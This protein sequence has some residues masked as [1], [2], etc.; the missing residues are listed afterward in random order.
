MITD[1]IVKLIDSVLNDEDRQ[2]LMLKHNKSTPPGIFIEQFKLLR[3]QVPRGL[4]TTTAA[5]KLLE[6]YDG[7]IL[8]V[9]NNA[10]LKYNRTIGNEKLY[11]PYLAE[12]LDNHIFNFENFKSDPIKAAQLTSFKNLSNEHPYE[13][14]IFDEINYDDPKNF[15]TID[16]ITH[17]LEKYTNL[18]VML[19]N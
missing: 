6:K 12:H 3:L 15:E 16:L 2:R 13:L 10:R 19:G 5:I 7:S 18:F 9:A 17:S 14:V 11:Y 4:G 1:N 8:F